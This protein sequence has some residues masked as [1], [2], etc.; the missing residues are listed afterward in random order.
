MVAIAMSTPDGDRLKTDQ[1]II[2]LLVEGTFRVAHLPFGSP[3]QVITD[4]SGGLPA[5]ALAWLR[6]PSVVAALARKATVQGRYV[7]SAECPFP[8]ELLSLL[9][10]NLIQ[11]FGKRRATQLRNSERLTDE[12]ALALEQH[13]AH[14]TLREGKGSWFGLVDLCHSDGRTACALI[15]EGP[16]GLVVSTVE[17]S[18]NQAQRYL[19]NYGYI[20]KPISVETSA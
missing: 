8:S 20:D 10:R 19:L 14:L 13:W 6:R 4:E 3:L 15:Q 9:D 5:H 11:L 12:E 17:V 1:E 7:D 16:D 2:D 18:R